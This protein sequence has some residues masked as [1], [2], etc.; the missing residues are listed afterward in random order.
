MKPITLRGA[1]L[2]PYRFEVYRRREKEV[3]KEV[4]EKGK[5]DDKL[6]RGPGVY[7][8]TQTLPDPSADNPLAHG[9]IDIGQED[10]VHSVFAKEEKPAYIL[11]HTGDDRLR[12]PSYR[13]EVVADLRSR[14]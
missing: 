1:S 7:I 10:D 11:T 8:L 5:E 6:P 13:D 12:N 9:V 14:T 4:G 3:E 2:T